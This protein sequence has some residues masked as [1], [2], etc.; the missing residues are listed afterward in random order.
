MTHPQS[1]TSTVRYGKKLVNA[2]ITGIRTGQNSARG[3]QKLST[4]AARAA[5][6]S[7]ALAAVGACV[8]LL[9]SYLGHRR[10]RVSNALALGTLG[11]ALGFVAGF[12]WKTRNVTSSVAHSTAREL[13]KARDEH[14]LESN[15]IDYA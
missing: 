2:G 4:L 8:G 13:R 14:W 11:S 10:N 9:R 7:L 12:G 6:N 3:E 1:V 5:R 15:P